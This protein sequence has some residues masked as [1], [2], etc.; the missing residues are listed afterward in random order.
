MIPLLRLEISTSLGAF[1][2]RQLVFL[3]NSREIKGKTRRFGE[4][5]EE[6]LRF[7]KDLKEEKKRLTNSLEALGLFLLKCFKTSTYITS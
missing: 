7:G 1:K 5:L 3:G 2:E 4:I 6:K